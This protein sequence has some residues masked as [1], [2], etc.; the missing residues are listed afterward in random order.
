ML[1]KII[2][3]FDLNVSWFFINVYKQNTILDGRK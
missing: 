3:W 2:K 1:K